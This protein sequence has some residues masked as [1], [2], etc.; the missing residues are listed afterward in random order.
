MYVVF[1]KVCY[2]TV[3]YCIARLEKA[4]INKPWDNQLAQKVFFIYVYYF[5][6]RAENVGII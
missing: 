1:M 4:C 3:K 5:S 6:A 2:G